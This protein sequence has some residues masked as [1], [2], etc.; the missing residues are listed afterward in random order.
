[1]DYLVIVANY[2]IF[3]TDYIAEIGLNFVLAKLPD[4]VSADNISIT[5]P[6]ER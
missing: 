5:G 2:L 1:M 3:I 6:L 4:Y